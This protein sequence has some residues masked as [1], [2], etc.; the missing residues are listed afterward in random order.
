[1]V[2]EVQLRAAADASRGA[3]DGRVDRP[4]EE[5]DFTFQRVPP[6]PLHFLQRLYFDH[7]GAERLRA[8]GAHWT[9]RAD[10]GKRLSEFVPRAVVEQR[11]CLVSGSAILVRNDNVLCSDLVAA[12]LF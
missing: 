1:M 11:H 8:P 5:Y 3:K 10:G 9:S 6:E 4:I 2:V 12:N 7:L